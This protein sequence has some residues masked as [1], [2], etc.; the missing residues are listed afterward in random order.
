MARNTVNK[1]KRKM[2]IIK[3]KIDHL[4]CLLEKA[5]NGEITQS[6]IAKEFGISNQRLNSSFFDGT[7]AL[8]VA[9]K[10]ATSNDLIQVLI[11]CETGY[12]KMFKAC[13]FTFNGYKYLKNNTN[14][15]VV[16]N[17]K[18]KKEFIKLLEDTLTDRELDMMKLYF[19]CYDKEYSCDEIAK[20]YNISSSRVSEIIHACVER[21]R[22]TNIFDFVTDDIKNCIMQPNDNIDNI[23][24]CY[25]IKLCDIQRKLGTRLYRALSTRFTTLGEVAECPKSEIKS[26]KGI[27]DQSIYDLEYILSKYNVR[28]KG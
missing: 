23:K 27:G 14:K 10:V 18:Q 24:K 12:E 19:G 1:G 3:E 9:S 25:N 28:L 13:F 15:I 20:K 4:S 11:D 5:Y 17:I 8:L 16:L 7:R 22:G 26:I 21:I 2:K 6:D